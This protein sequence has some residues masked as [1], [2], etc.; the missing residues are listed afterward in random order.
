MRILVFL[1]GKA[2]ES[3]LHAEGEEH[4]NQSHVCIEIRHHAVTAARCCDDVCV[5]RNEQVI[6]KSAHYAAKSVDG[7]VLSK[8]FH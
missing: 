3:R 7:G 6:E 4:E 1:V 5:K 2:K 8:R